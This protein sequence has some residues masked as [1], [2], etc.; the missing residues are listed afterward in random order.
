MGTGNKELGQTLIE[1]VFVLAL[2]LLL[3]LGIAEFARAWYVKNSIN[4]AARIGARVGVVTPDLAAETDTLCSA[5][6]SAVATAVCNSLSVPAAALADIKVSVCA[7]LI[8]PTTGVCTTDVSKG[9]DPDALDAGD[10]V[11]VRVKIDYLTGF[12]P[13]SLLPWLKS[14]TSLSSQASMRY[15]L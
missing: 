5:P 7:G 14:L 15:E 10:T 11:T 13:F 9:S 1:T 2:L 8:D 6:V 3:I 4:N 12:S